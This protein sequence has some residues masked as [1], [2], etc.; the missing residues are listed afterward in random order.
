MKPSLLLVATVALMLSGVGPI[1]AGMIHSGSTP[2]ELNAL[3][4]LEASQVELLAI[5]VI[6]PQPIGVQ[7][8]GIWVGT[9]TSTGWSLQF[10]AS[11]D[12]LPISIAQA[13]IL[14]LANDNASWPATGTV[15]SDLLLDSESIVF[16]PR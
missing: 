7:H 9:I 8:L 13:G 10:D 1:K 15:G 11:F 12:N 4:G 3:V 5:A 16:K 6:S 14:D 2:V